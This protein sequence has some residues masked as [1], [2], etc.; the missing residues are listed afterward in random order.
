MRPAELGYARSR[1]VG[2][3]SLMDDAEDVDSFQYFVRGHKS[4]YLC[5]VDSVK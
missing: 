1:I 3:Y 5:F 4:E 2:L